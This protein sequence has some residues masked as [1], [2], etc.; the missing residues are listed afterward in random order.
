MQTKKSQ[1][2]KKE[3]K[4]VSHPH[5]KT[6]ENKKQVICPL[7]K[8]QVRIKNNHE[9]KEGLNKTYT[10]KLLLLKFRYFLGEKKIFRGVVLISN[11]QPVVYICFAF[12]AKSILYFLIMIF[13]ANPYVKVF[14]KFYHAGDFAFFVRWLF[15][16]KFLEQYVTCAI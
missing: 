15:S 5:A 16:T 13:D 3:R 1:L 7:V 11:F 2:G 14:L 10:C 6:E 8:T 9:K 4:Y 12:I